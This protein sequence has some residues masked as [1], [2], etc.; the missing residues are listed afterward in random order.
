VTARAGQRAALAVRVTHLLHLIAL[1]V[2]RH[3][4]RRPVIHDFPCCMLQSRR[5]RP[6]ARPHAVHVCDSNNYGTFTIMPLI[7]SN[8][9]P[10]AAAATPRETAPSSIIPHPSGRAAS[11]RGRFGG[12]PQRS[13]CGTPRAGAAYGS[14]GDSVASR[15]SLR[16]PGKD[17]IK[18]SQK[19][20][21]RIKIPR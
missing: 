1:R 13:A 8:D 15:G 7:I 21:D 20:I 2:H 19:N 11:L 5:C 9:D 3:G 18:F 17:S 14:T 12:A 6:D 4:G 16:P 10:T